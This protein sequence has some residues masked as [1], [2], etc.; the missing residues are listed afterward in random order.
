MNAAPTFVMLCD[1]DLELVQG[2]HC[3][4]MLL[5]VLRYWNRYR[6]WVEATQEE[7]R[8]ALKGL[9]SR[10]RIVMALKL[11][12]QNG[13]VVARENA[14]RQVRTLQ[15]QVVEMPV[16][17]P[18]EDIGNPE[19]DFE[20]PVQDIENP[21]AGVS[22]L[23]KKNLES[24]SWEES[25]PQVREGDEP[26]QGDDDDDCPETVKAEI[27]QVKAR[28][29]A[30]RVREVLARCEG[31][32]RSWHYVLKALRNEVQQK[33]PSPRSALPPPSYAYMP[34]VDEAWERHLAAGGAA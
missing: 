24:E 26:T 6:D 20:S 10:N 8:V 15:Y 11:L 2:D 22:T 29:G 33:R 21:V 9:F 17:Q 1:D 7:M 3:A 34:P 14:N 28:I 19:Q 32:A 25:S 30:D 27:A 16:G 5:S 4:A 23:D 31:K 13:F 18:R 12:R